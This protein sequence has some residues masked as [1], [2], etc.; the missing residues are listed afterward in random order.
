MKKFVQTFKQYHPIVN[1][2]LFGTIILAI[3]SCI[4]I[5]YLPLYLLKEQ[6]YNP[7]KIGLIVGVGSLAAT[8]SG[9]IAG[10]VSDFIGRRKVMLGSLYLSSFVFFGFLISKQ[11]YFLILMMLLQGI[12]TS[13][14]GPVSKALVADLTAVQLRMRV[15]SIR[16]II[17]NIGYAIGPSIGAY[18]WLTEIIDPFMITGCLYLCYSVLLHLLLNRYGIKQ[19]EGEQLKEPQTVK[20]AFQVLKYDKILLLFVLGGLI[21]TVVHGQWSVTIQQYLND[22]FING[23]MLYTIVLTTNSVCVIL[24]QYPISRWAERFKPL[25]MV[26]V[27][28]ILFSIGMVGFAFSSNWTLFIL[29]MGIFTI[30]EIMV[31]PSEYM[32]IDLITPDRLRGMYYGAQNLTGVGSFLGPVIG[33]YLLLHFGGNIMFLG[34]ALLG[35]ISIFLFW[36]GQSLQDRQHSEQ[37]PITRY[38]P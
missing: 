21:S 25:T 17:N 30:G 6:H 26:V 29:S 27:G 12:S 9:F 20:G 33:G 2:L 36:R 14:F 31:I 22:N 18:L 4:S 15:F 19:I 37:A 34:F 13:F 3:G 16:Y 10:I 38:S 23:A 5:L 24:F 1:T 28:S 11:T 8:F 35:I 32:M 7:V